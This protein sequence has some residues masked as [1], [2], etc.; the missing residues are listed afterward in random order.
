M[1]IRRNFFEVNGSGR[2]FREVDGARRNFF[3]TNGQGEILRRL[4]GQKKFFRVNGSKKFFFGKING[5]RAF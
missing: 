1:R 3:E 4:M 2:F 5:T